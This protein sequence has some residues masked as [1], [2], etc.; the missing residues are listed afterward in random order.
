MARLVLA[1]FRA[2]A[3]RNLL[4][5]LYRTLLRLYAPDIRLRREFNRWAQN[6][7]DE[8]M[9]LDHSWLAERIIPKLGFLPKTVSSILAVEVGGPA[10]AS[11]RA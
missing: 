2:P 4:R 7:M 11:Q 10:A 5:G 1:P 9:E 3:V 6:G 8:T